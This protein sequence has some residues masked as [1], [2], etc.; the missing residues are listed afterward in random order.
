MVFIQVHHVPLIQ[1]I[2]SVIDLGYVTRLWNGTISCIFR[3]V[4][5]LIILIFKL[6]YFH[7]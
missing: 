6:S 5:V 1:V 4:S 7:N 2:I 3:K